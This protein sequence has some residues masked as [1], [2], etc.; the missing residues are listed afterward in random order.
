MAGTADFDPNFDDTAWTEA[1]RHVPLVLVPPG[2]HPSGYR[3][4]RR[5]M[6]AADICGRRYLL[7]APFDCRL[8][9]DPQGRLWMSNTPQELLMMYNNARRSR[10]RVLI[11]GLGLGLYPQ[12]AVIV[13][14]ERIAGFHVIERSPVVQAI[15]RPVL[16]RVLPVPL[17]VTLGDIAEYLA[18]PPAWRYDTIFLDTW[19][20]LDAAQLPAINRLRDLARRHLAPGGRVLLWGYRWMVRLFEDACRQVLAVEPSKRAAWLA[21]RAGDSPEALPLLAPVV[22]RFAGDPVKDLDVALAWCREYIVQAVAPI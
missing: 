3:V 16:E 18:G 9:Y 13:G 21:A 1:W 17:T 7:P 2:V 11:G 14:E 20:T 19:D 22:E 15:T 10:G 12:F 8:L 5:T 6:E 4:V